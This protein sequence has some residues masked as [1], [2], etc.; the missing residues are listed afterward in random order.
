MHG[1][2]VGA[3]LVVFIFLVDFASMTDD[4]SLVGWVLIIIM[5][6]VGLMIWR[7]GGTIRGACSPNT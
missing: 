2:G 6:A 1:K 3:L 7:I 5:I 4:P